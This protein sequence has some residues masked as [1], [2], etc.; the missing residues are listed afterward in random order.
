MDKNIIL[1][2][3]NIAP[4]RLRWCEELS[5]Y[6]DVVIYH[7]QDREINYNDEFLKHDSNKCKVI[8]LK[9]KKDKYNPIC[10]DV[11]N[12]I[13]ENKDSFIIFD[14]YG[15]KTNLLGLFY[16][17]L[18]GI[19]TFVNVDGYPTERKKSR[20]REFVKGFVIKNLCEN[21]FCGGNTVIEY[22]VKYGAKRSNIYVHNFSSITNDRILTK[23]LSRKQKLKIRKEIGINSDKKIVL[24]VGRFI[25]LKRFEDLIQ[26]VINCEY[27]CELY[28]LGGKPNKSY[29]DI[30][31]NN[32]NIHFIDFVLPEEVDKYYQS[33]DL[34]VLPSETDVWGLV[35]NEAMAQGLPVISSDS[36]VAAA[37]MINNNGFIFKTYDVDDLSKKIILC[38]DDKTNLNMSQNSLKIIKEFTIE[39]M[40]E[41]QLPVI[42]KYFE[43]K[44]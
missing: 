17:K 36:P 24:G 15:P 18:K 5:K 22:L 25:P 1:I 28:L 23:P 37:N 35:I 43:C 30:V 7:T 3:T 8:K 33:A 44:I 16:C 40:V 4:Y 26:A 10:F 34:F 27:D 2:T 21:F 41:K 9:N 39:K 19:K 38:L 12:V 32:K 42:M 6:F 11:I 13:K 14:G 29:L 31:N 20:I